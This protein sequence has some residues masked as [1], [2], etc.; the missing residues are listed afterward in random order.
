MFQMNW[1]GDTLTVIHETQTP[2]A[3]SG[4]MDIEVHG[5]ITAS[6]EEWLDV[7]VGI[8]A[9]LP[10][11]PNPQKTGYL[12]APAHADPD[13]IGELIATMLKDRPPFR[14]GQSSR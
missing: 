9:M 4:G 1:S 14:H 10:G 12:L 3:D 2:N 11:K 7:A 6:G 5:K 8:L 13:M